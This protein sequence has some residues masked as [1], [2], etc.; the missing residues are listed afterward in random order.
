MGVSLVSF[1]SSNQ[2]RQVSHSR[3]VRCASPAS[4][5]VNCARSAGFLIGAGSSQIDYRLTALVHH[6]PAE[7]GG[8]LVAVDGT[9]RIMFRDNN[10]GGDADGN[11]QAA[12]P[13]KSTELTVLAPA[14]RS[15]FGFVGDQGLDRSHARRE[16]G[17]GSHRGM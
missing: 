13:L 5:R 15:G 1:C 9:G 4:I 7:D 8:I 6:R 12:G 16:R 17:D 10:G 2:R 14:T 11:W 3:W